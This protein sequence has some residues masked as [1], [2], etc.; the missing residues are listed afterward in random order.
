MLVDVTSEER[1]VDVRVGSDLVNVDDD[2]PA[3]LE[4]DAGG[5]AYLVG[6]DADLRHG[7]D[8]LNDAA[9]VVAQYVFCE[10][11]VN[12]AVAVLTS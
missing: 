9:R 3:F 4:E 8:A 11:S 10:W 5:E 6:R 12:Y 7:D 2:L 1:A